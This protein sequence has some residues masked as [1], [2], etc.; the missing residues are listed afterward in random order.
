MLPAVARME[1]DTVQTVHTLCSL[2]TSLP[3]SVFSSLS[4]SKENKM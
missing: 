2:E 4:F 3:V 1:I